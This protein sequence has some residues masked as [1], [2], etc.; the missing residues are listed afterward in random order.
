MKLQIPAL[1]TK[2]KLSMPWTFRLFQEHRNGLFISNLRKAGFDIP[3]PPPNAPYSWYSTTHLTNVTLPV[4]TILSVK[5]IYIRSGQEEYNS[6]TFNAMGDEIKGRFWVKLD[7]ANN[8]EY[9][10]ATVA[11]LVKPKKLRRKKV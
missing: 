7:D 5:R 10:L 8:I 4:G 11:D 9:E 3:S 1:D 2:I 6:I